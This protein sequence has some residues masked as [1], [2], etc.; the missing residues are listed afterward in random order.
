MSTKIIIENDHEDFSGDWI[1]HFQ[2]MVHPGNLHSA[3]SFETSSLG[4]ENLQCRP[5][6]TILTAGEVLGV[7]CEVLGLTL[8]EVENGF[9]SRDE[10]GNHRVVVESYKNKGRVYEANGEK[11]EKELF[12]FFKESRRGAWSVHETLPRDGKKWTR[13]D[14]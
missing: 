4:L 5:L 8:D 6:K 2:K 3:E 9:L 12:F 11:G 10:N 13:V 14:W 7:E 1:V